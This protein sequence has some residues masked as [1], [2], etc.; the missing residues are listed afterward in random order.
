MSRSNAPLPKYG[1]KRSFASFETG[2]T[3]LAVLFLA[4]WRLFCVIGRYRCQDTGKNVHLAGLKLVLWLPSSILST[5]DVIFSRSKVSLPKYRQN[6]SFASFETSFTAFAVLF[7]CILE[8]IFSLSKVPLT[9]YGQKH[10]FADFKTGF[11]PF[12]VLFLALWKLY[13]VD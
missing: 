8:V 6:C 5:L 7:F 9:R 10:S 3:A 13:C 2:F 12:T 11:S 1:R 4:F